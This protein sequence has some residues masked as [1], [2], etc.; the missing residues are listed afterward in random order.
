MNIFKIIGDLLGIGKD[1]LNN[2]A[3]LNRLKAQQQH[4]ILEAQTKAQV[5]RILS[6]TDSDNQIDLI[7]AQDK[8]HSLKDEVVTYLFLIP[9]VIAT[10]SPFIIAYKE[11]N[12]THLAEDV[13]ISY[14][15]LDCLPDWYKY[16]LAAIIIDVLGF[17]SFAR[18]LIG[19]YI[20]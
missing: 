8:K 17:R 18:K 20:K 7:T 4:S 11:S 19:K 1:A 9:V 12:F 15:N 2:K 14:E 6:N 3:E 5:D 10:V 13:R 16:V